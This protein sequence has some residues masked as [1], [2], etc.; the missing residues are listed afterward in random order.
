MLQKLRRS[1]EQECGCTMPQFD[2]LAQLYRNGKGLTFVEL[3]RRLLVT[4]GN[5]TGIVDRLEA[6]GYVLRAPDT[7]DRRVI[8][9]ELTSAGREL[10]AEMAPR[11]ASDVRE[12]MNG[13]SEPDQVALSRILGTLKDSLQESA[14]SGE[15]G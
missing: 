4:S 7:R 6:A 10:I 5:L 11:H 9:V 3:S 13:L 15:Q 8:R 12:M 14:S 1:V 2:V